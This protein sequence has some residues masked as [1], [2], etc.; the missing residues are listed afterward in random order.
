MRKWGRQSTRVY[1]SLDPRL[2]TWCDRMLHEVS[3]ISLISGYRGRIEQTSYYE[4]NVSKHRYPNSK[5]NHKPSLAVDLQPYPKPK[6]TY[7]LWGALGFLAGR[8]HYI[9]TDM[10][11]T[12]RWGGDWDTDGD[13]TDQT[14]D[15]LFHFEVAN[16]SHT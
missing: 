13:L 9:A 8:G 12:L 2:Q 7:K 6:H 4:N 16:E 14:F 10:G 15:D 5:H 3:D 1:N 11:I